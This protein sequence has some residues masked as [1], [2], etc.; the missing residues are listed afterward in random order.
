MSKVYL[1]LSDDLRECEGK[2]VR[3]VLDP[4]DAEILQR[5]INPH[6]KVTEM[7]LEYSPDL[8]KGEPWWWA[9][10]WCNSRD[11]NP[12]ITIHASAD[13]RVEAHNEKY[14]GGFS[15]FVD[16]RGRMTLW[17]PIRGPTKEYAE[18]V[19][20]EEV[21]RI[22]ALPEVKALWDAPADTDGCRRL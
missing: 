15:V 8:P 1:V 18:K 16:E 10:V 14:P 19:G 12:N 2:P 22:M 9:Y 11:S 17:V 20:T 4:D 21:L 7:E 6:Y 13:S 3:A 5:R